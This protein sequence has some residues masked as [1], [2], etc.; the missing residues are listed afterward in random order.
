[1]GPTLQAAALQFVKDFEIQDFQASSGWV[2]SFE[3]GNLISQ[4]TLELGIKI[5]C[6]KM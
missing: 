5:K 2:D 4:K 3:K 6:H 1:L